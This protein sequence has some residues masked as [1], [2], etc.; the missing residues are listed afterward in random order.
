MY[1]T[2]YN[3]VS[4]FT[5]EPCGGFSDLAERLDAKDKDSHLHNLG[6]Q[7]RLGALEVC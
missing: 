3:Y 1:S 6:E 2:Y 7:R 4:S 5:P